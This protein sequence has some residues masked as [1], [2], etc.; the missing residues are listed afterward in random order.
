MDLNSETKPAASLAGVRIERVLL[1]DDES[2]HL[3]KD[4]ITHYRDTMAAPTGPAPRARGSLDVAGM[5]GL[6]TLCA[7]AFAL[8]LLI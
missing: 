3:N 1:D 7:A 4:D 5:A 2:R 8:I 6:I